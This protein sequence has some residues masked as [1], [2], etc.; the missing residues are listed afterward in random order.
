MYTDNI[1]Q[2]IY[3]S[4]V[5][6]GEDLTLSLSSLIIYLASHD[7]KIFLYSLLRGISEKNTTMIKKDKYD[8]KQHLNNDAIKGNAALIFCLVK[9]STALK[10]ALTDWLVG[11]C[12]DGVG[13]DIFIHRIT[14]AALSGDEG[15]V[16]L[17]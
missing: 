5:T 15:E 4:C 17:I 8:S 1:V 14:I 9:N 6:G 13:Q 16:I 12:G 2:S 3:K 7:Q 11:A 10:N